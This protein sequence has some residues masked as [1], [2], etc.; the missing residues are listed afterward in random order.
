MTGSMDGGMGWGVVDI[1][2]G[3]SRVLVRDCFCFTF[4]KIAF[5]Y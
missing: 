4:A 1:L 2:A 3:H 5:S